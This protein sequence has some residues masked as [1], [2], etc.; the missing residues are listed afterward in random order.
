[1]NKDDAYNTLLMAMVM[2]TSNA[3]EMSEKMG[4]QEVAQG[5]EFPIDIKGMT[6]PELE[7]IGFVFGEPIDELFQEVT[8]P[9]GWKIQPTEH[10][11]WSNIL[12]EKGNNRGSIFYKAAFYD[13]CAFASVK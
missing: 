8:L 11:M 5:C 7:A 1:M 4:Q 2:G 9:Q 3:I 12:D 13:R 10:S 6:K